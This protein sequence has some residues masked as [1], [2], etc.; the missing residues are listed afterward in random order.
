M[1]LRASSMTRFVVCSL[2]PTIS[3]TLPELRG[4]DGADDELA[5]GVRQ[6]GNL[7]GGTEDEEAGH[8]AV[9]EVPGE[10]LQR[11]GVDAAVGVAG[12]DDRGD[13]ALE[14]GRQR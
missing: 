4:G 14:L 5:L 8:A 7:A 9:E 11:A 2:A 6:V 13:D 10:V 3:G 12:G 1:T